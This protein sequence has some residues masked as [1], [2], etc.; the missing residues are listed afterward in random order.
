MRTFTTVDDVM[1][2]LFNEILTGG[3]GSDDRTGVGTKRLFG[4]SARLKFTHNKLMVPLFK[5]VNIKAVAAELYCFINGITNVDEL[6][7]HG[8]N[9]WEANLQAANAK[10]GTPD[11]RDLGPVYGA[12]WVKP[13]ICGVK[14]EG[15]TYSDPFGYQ[16]PEYTTQLERLIETLKTNPADRRM[17]VTAWNPEQ[18]ADMALPPCYHGFQCFVNEKNEL[19]LMFHMRS[20]DVLLG[21]PHDI[22]LHQ[23]LLIM[24]AAQTGKRPGDLLF[25]LGDYHLYNNSLDAV[26]Q[27]RKRLFKDH[28]CHDPASD[29]RPSIKSIE[30]VPLMDFQV[31][32]VQDMIDEY[33]PQANIKVQMAV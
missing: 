3:E 27:F 19:D 32:D 21:L 12:Q 25:T 15:Q 4:F 17:Y 10:W 29:N 20:A 6:K 9:W 14:V 8:C 2:T 7:R 13:F 16:V 1:E 33:K 5:P 23:L 22:L 28:D 24:L 18:F 31:T 11:N 26:E 30:D